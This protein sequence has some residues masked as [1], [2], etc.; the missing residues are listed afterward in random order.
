MYKSPTGV[1]FNSLA[2]PVD[3]TPGTKPPWTR[4]RP[5]FDFG[6]GN[7]VFSVLSTMPKPAKSAD[8]AG[9][10]MVESE[11]IRFGQVSVSAVS[12]NAHSATTEL[13]KI[14]NH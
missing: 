13:T 3:N 7:S 8:W 9:F 1:I 14:E 4:A 2:S 12:H 11:N 10:G 5:K 6:M